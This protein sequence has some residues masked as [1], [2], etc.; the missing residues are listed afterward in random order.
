MTTF[1]NED[2]ALPD[3]PAAFT[4]HTPSGATHVCASHARQIQ[5]VMRLLGAHV[6]F[7]APPPGAQC[8]NCENEAAH[9]IKETS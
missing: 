3:M 8:K 9:G 6:N 2:P 1:N 5:H 4:A 7:T